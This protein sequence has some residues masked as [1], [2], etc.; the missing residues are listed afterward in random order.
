M[1]AWLDVVVKLNPVTYGVDVM[2]KIMVDVENL[3]ETV[4]ETMGL[5]LTVFGRQVTIFEEILFI[6]AFTIIMIILATFS[7]KRAN[8]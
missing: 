6:A 1:P 7:F 3:S 8:A 2:K 5:N 4:M